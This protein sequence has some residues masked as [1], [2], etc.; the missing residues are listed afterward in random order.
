[1]KV[2]VVTPYYKES[3]KT[4]KR[5]LDSVAKQTHDDVF[6]VL[7]GD[8]YPQDW[9]NDFTLHHLAMPNVGNYGDTPRGIGA[10]YAAGVGADAIIFLDADCW[11]PHY[12]VSFFVE[13]V[14][15]GAGIVTCPRNIWLEGEEM[16]ICTESNGVHFNDTNCY[17][18]TKPYFPVI[19]AW[20]FKN[21][22]DSIVGDR[23]FWNA[24]QRSGACILSAASM[25]NYESD[26]AH[27]YQMFGR[28]PPPDSKL[29]VG[30]KVVKWREVC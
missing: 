14:E 20:M 10:A 9:V 3:R 1:M 7:V 15:R 23:V 18:I 19:S 21:Q 2:A 13:P 29:L 11:M 28:T 16:G 17:L 5:C 12:H 22:K 24:V 6:H 26:F 27:H 4:L 8:G 25:V 30:D